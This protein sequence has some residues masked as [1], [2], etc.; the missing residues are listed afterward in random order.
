MSSNDTACKRIS[1]RLSYSGLLCRFIQSHVSFHVNRKGRKR[2]FRFLNRHPGR[3]G[4]ES[5]EHPI[6]PLLPSA[7]ADSSVISGTWDRTDKINPLSLGKS[8]LQQAPGSR[9]RLRRA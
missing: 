2:V 5:E 8:A 6:F 9:P 7:D 1:L 4:A 3:N